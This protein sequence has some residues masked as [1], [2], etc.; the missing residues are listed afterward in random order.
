MCGCEICIHCKKLQRNL[1]SWRNRHAC[2][3]YRYKFVVFSD[4]SLLHL[5]PRDVINRMFY[6]KHL[7]SIYRNGS[8]CLDNV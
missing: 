6:P 4:D 2:N 5:S 7:V 1:N 3:K 8:A